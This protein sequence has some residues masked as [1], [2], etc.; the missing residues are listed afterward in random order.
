MRLSFRSHPPE[1]PF[2]PV[3]RAV[4]EKTSAAP[5]GGV[6]PASAFAGMRYAGVGSARRVRRYRWPTK[7]RRRYAHGDRPP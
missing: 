1:V 5:S 3:L 7:Q 6:P 4:S 2:A